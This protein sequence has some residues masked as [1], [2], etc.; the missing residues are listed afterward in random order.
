MSTG[1]VFHP[2]Y[3]WHDTGT[4]AGLLPAHPTAGIQPAVHI[5]NPEAKRRAHE[6]IHASGLLAELVVI[7]PRRATVTEL[8]RVHTG[9]HLQHIKAQSELRGGGDAGDG[10]SPV[11]HGSYDIARLA[12][13]GL[14]ELVTAVAQGDITNGYALTR[15]PGH[16]ATADSGIGFCLF[17]A[18][19]IAARHAQAELGLARIAVVDWDAHH[20]N[21]TQSIFYTDPTV[22]T[23]SLHQ[24]G[25]F[26]PD[27][28]WTHENGAGDGLGYALNLPLP[29]G[30]GHAAYL[31]AMTEVVLPALDRFAPDLILL[32]NGF[33]AGV[34]DPMARQMLTSASYREMTRLLTDAAGRLCH[35]RLVAAHEGGYSP[36]YTPYCVLAFLEE[37]AGT[38]THVTD[39]LA[40]VVASY[41][42]EPL[43]PQQQAVI[44]EATQL[45]AGI[46]TAASPATR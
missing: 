20:G 13:G 46:R 15:P 45:V 36:F 4:S 27:S 28:G 14:I 7:E 10:F 38:T 21:G 24:A 22:L 30:S 17:N 41:A 44:N 16:H 39:P 37:L 8:L 43:T 29:P 12:A 33:D 6:L 23:I 5:E 11:G 1:Y 18:I 35:G 40:A 19:A 26:P 42:A 9:E 2:E 34:F 32:A 3:L 31:H 25:C